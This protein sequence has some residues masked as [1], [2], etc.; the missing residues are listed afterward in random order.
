[1]QRLFKLFAGLL[2]GLMFVTT[3]SFSI[4]EEA[5]RILQFENPHT[6]LDFGTVALGTP[7]TKA[8][9]LL[10]TG[11]SDL[12]VY[13]VRFHDKLEGAYSSDFSESLVVPAGGSAVVNITFTPTE[14][15]PYIGLV[16]IESD[17][18]NL[19]QDR[20]HLIKGMGES[21]P[22]ETRILQFE[23]PHTPLNFADA[24]ICEPTTQVLKL[25]NTGNSPL[26]ITDIRFHENLEDAYSS[27]FVPDKIIPAGGFIIVNIT[28]IPTEEKLYRGLVYIESDRTNINQDRSL[29]LSGNGLSSCVEDSPSDGTRILGFENPHT[30]FN[31]NAVPVDTSLTKQLKI[32]NSGDSAL[33]INQI[34]FHERLEGSYTTDF[35]P[36]EVIPAGSFIMVNITFTPTEEKTYR[37]LV[38][39]ESD[40]TNL[41]QDRSLLLQG[42]GI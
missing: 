31:F 41:A 18:T 7:V 39:V 1:M 33:T 9:T 23:N 26:T 37:G 20:S 2:F 38:Y 5:T 19:A 25:M 32:M 29:L 17:R 13:R 35:I 11:N 30:L 10:N 28:F 42:T 4:G 15:Q 22:V 12:T 6:P 3:T 40:R 34:R 27:D 36:N 14:E 16:Y 8:L 21:T 24:S